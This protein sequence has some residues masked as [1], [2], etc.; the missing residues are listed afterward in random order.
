MFTL[1]TP[2]ALLVLLGLLVPVAIHLWNRRPGR[3][4]P[5]GSLRWLAAG[6]NRRL[7]NLKP[8]QLWL[9]LLRAALLAALAVAVAGPVWRQPLP[10]GRGQILV[11]PD[12]LGNPALGTLR[13]TIDSLRR[14]GYGLRWLAAGFPNMSGAAWRAGSAGAR[15]SARL[16]S[17]AGPAS[18]HGWARVQ[19]AADSF[20][21]QPL[22]VVSNALLRGFQGQHVPLPATVTWQ[23]LPTAATKTWL[24]S[25]AL[26]GDSLQ[27]VLATSREAQ[28]T[29]RRVTAARP[30]AGAEVRPAGLPLLRYETD[31]S[32]SRLVLAKAKPEGS[33]V[34]EFPV[35][36]RTRPYRIVVYATADF[37][38]DARYLQAALRAASAGLPVPLALNLTSTPPPPNPA[39]D[40]LLWLAD[41]PLPPAWLAAVNH[42]TNVWQEAA[43]PGTASPATLAAAAA[44]EPPTALFR[45]GA[46]AGQS[47][48]TALSTAIWVDGQ[49]RSVLT[50]Q[51]RG[52]GILYQL[53]T[54]LNPTWSELADNPSLPAHLLRLLHPDA[55]D[56]QPRTATTVNPAEAAH[57]QRAIDPAQLL[58]SPPGA[59]GSVPAL[60]GAA[61]AAAHKT[62]LRPWLVLAAGLL[63]A[64][65]RLLARRRARQ[66]SPALP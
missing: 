12:V 33:L 21:R 1:L 4:V 59:L 22:Y 50:A 29:F 30:R 46:P 18:A 58:A 28:T 9:L 6:A 5:V 34:A 61:P 32:G 24:Q 25:A 47:K 39:P 37:S 26:V 35:A 41:A 52:R 27:L 57:D 49:G 36:V 43:A 10:V 65:E 53:H 19:Q 23:T 13:P 17:A 51:A 2:S 55:T 64:S 31:V 48:S 56:A 20:A 11:S 7:R 66:L 8:E 15:D 38:P 42:G 63:F 14:R 62:D 60:G 40:W 3:E 44:D 16:L 54:R 45:R